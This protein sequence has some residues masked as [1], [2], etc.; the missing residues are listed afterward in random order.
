[1]TFTESPLKGCF[2][3]EPRVFEDH[4]GYF[5]ESFNQKLLD[6]ALGYSPQ[7]VQDN[8]SRS[9]YG[10][11]RG[12]HLQTGRHAQAKLVRALEGEIW[13]VVVDVRPGS[14]TYGQSYGILLSAENKKQ[15]FIPRGFAHGFAVLSEHATIHYKADNYYNK[16]SESGLLY[17]DPAL[18]IDWRLPSEAIITSEK[19]KLLPLLAE[20]KGD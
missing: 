11:I 14:A 10:V 20:F 12:L 1:M 8:Q 18:A 4:R 9:H 17:S 16:E 6:E 2:I 13:D 5:F 19:D 15:L 7:F 3:I